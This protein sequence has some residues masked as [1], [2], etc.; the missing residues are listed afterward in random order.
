MTADEIDKQILYQLQQDARN[1]TNTAISERIGVSPSTI[2]KRIGTLE[3]QGIIEGYQ[4]TINYGRAQFP[5]RVLFVCTTA[6]PKR[7]EF[8]EQLKGTPGIVSI[9]ELMTGEENIHIEVLGKDN[10]DITELAG[11]ID[12]L[13]VTINEEILVKND[14]RY[15]S[16]VF[17]ETLENPEA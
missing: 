4:P 14:Y 3:D 17:Q 10:E 9:K 15:P 13:G 1:N 16:S 7:A 8:I 2:G 5:L 6:V 12:G 11:K